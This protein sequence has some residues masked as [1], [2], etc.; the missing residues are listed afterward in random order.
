MSV[1]PNFCGYASVFNLQDQVG[2]VILP[3]AFRHSVNALNSK[4]IKLLWQ[5]NP[6]LPLGNIQRLYED[7]KG[8]Y[9]EGDFLL[10]VKY[11]DE[12]YLLIKNRIVQGLSIGFEAEDSFFSQ[13]TRYIK[14]AKLWEISVVTFPANAAAQILMVGGNGLEPSTS[15]MST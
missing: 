14:Q 5:H 9:I 4:N 15:T 6:V 7:T 8:L 13:D 12:A 10:G 11:V 1:A 3:G 2:D